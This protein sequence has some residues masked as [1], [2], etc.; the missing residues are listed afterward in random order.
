MTEPILSLDPARRTNAQAVA[1]LA[2]LGFC[3]EPV[4]D[5]TYGRGKFWTVH[6]PDDLF[7]N[8]LR[9]PADMAHDYRRPWPRVML[10]RFATVVFDPPYKLNGTPTDDD[11]YGVDEPAAM[12]ERLASIV[13]GLGFA[14]TLVAPGG[15]LWVKYQDQVACGRMQWQSDLITRGLGGADF[16]RE[17]RMFVH[18]GARPQR[19]QKR[20]RNNYSTLEVWRAPTS[21]NQPGD[22]HR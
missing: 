8:D 1:Q 14:A 2:A 10:R 12:T 18:T 5:T 11:R 15:Y 16:T 6:R 21:I 13:T 3:P 4:I 22:H 9:T 7:T 19:S 17:A 20:P